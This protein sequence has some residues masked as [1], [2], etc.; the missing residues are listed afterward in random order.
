MAHV[1]IAAEDEFGLLSPGLQGGAVPAPDAVRNLAWALDGLA[2]RWRFMWDLRSLRGHLTPEVLQTLSIALSELDA[3]TSQPILVRPGRADAVKEDF[4]WNSSLPQVPSIIEMHPKPLPKRA[5]DLRLFEEAELDPYDVV[6]RLSVS[7]REYVESAI[8]LGLTSTDE[9]EGLETQLRADQEGH[10]PPPSD[11]TTDWL[12]S[13][14]QTVER[15][16]D[17]WS[18]AVETRRVE[19]VRHVLDAV[20]TNS[21]LVQVALHSDESGQIHVVPYH[22]YALHG[23]ATQPDD[24][25]LMRPGRVSAPYWSRFRSAILALERL[26]NDPRVQERQIELLLLENP[27]FLRGLNYGNVYSQ[28]VLPRENAP[29]LRPD[30]IAEPLGQRWADIIDLKRPVGTVLVGSE[31]RVRLA[32]ALTEAAAQ[33]REYRAYFDDRALAKR[34]EM[35]LGIRCYKPKMVVIVG[36]DPSGYSADQQ[37][38]A[39][40]AY[41]NLEIVSYDQLL[42]IARDQLLL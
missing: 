40:T 39:M 42:R 23:V 38:R 32:A 14:E 29:D 2:D 6:D 25:I 41:P 31:S 28:V 18:Q 21:L 36:R 26:L 22:S 37:R 9:S 34:V 8:A 33:L 11:R 4:L 16:G 27:L 3:S 15:L 35:E 20:A 7:E 24:V 13:I 12:L 30:L 17:I 1:R 10:P 19:A 5:L